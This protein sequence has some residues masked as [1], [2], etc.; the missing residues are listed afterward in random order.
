MPYLKEMRAHTH[1][2]TRPAGTPWYLFWRRRREHMWGVR[3]ISRGAGR[4]QL[5]VDKMEHLDSRPLIGAKW[6]GEYHFNV[7]PDVLFILI[8]CKIT[9]C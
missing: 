7:S 1:A 2:H 6:L 8:N 4:P 5:R 3:M 9:C